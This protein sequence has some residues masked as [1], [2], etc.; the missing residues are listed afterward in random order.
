MGKAMTVLSLELH[1]LLS[2]CLS[3]VHMLRAG[4]RDQCM[5][6]LKPTKQSETLMRKC[7]ANS[8][9]SEMHVGYVLSGQLRHIPRQKTGN[10]IHRLR[11][12]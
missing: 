6:Q 9:Y 12:P 5:K 2:P 4:S 7:T 11:L 10:Y 3:K 8:P 1:T